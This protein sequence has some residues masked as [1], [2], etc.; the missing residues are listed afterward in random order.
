LQLLHYLFP[1]THTPARDHPLRFY[2]PIDYSHYQ[3]IEKLAFVVSDG[4][5][6]NR[7]VTVLTSLI[8]TTPPPPPLN[9]QVPLLFLLRT[10]SVTGLTDHPTPTHRPNYAILYGEKEKK[11]VQASDP[12]KGRCLIEN[13]GQTFGI[14][15]CHCIPRKEMNNDKLVSVYRIHHHLFRI[16]MH[17][18]AQRT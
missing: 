17:I 8:V 16:L 3:N 13:R 18:I 15:Y 11:R 1:H 2:F 12:N 14:N 7:H 4:D 5:R 10:M 6:I 9:G